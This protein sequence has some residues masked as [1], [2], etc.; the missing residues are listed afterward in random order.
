MLGPPDGHT[1]ALSTVG[2]GVPRML[3]PGPA[4][5]VTAASALVPEPQAH[6]LLR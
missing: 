1:V 2:C 5:L 3:A 6:P 4:L